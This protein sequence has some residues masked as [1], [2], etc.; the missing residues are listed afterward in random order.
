[1][2][3]PELTFARI[4]LD[5]GDLIRNGY[6]SRHTRADQACVFLSLTEECRL[7]VEEFGLDTR[8]DSTVGL[9]YTLLEAR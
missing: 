8:V 6:L 2:G 9:A 3:D 7:V 5:A 1:M 4:L